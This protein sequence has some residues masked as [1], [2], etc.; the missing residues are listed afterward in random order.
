MENEI[1]HKNIIYVRDISEIGGVETYVYEL[2]KKYK[3]YDI[4]VVFKSCHPNQLARLKRYCYCYQHINQK[5][6]CDVAIINYDSSIIDFITKDIWKENLKEDDPRGIYQG[7]HADYTN[8]VYTVIPQDYRV[9]EYLCITKHVMKTYRELIHQD[10]MRL[11]YN[12]LTIDEEPSPL[13]LVSATRLSIIKGK[14]RMISLAKALDKAKVNYIWYVFTNDTNAINNP[15]IIYMAPRLDVYKW[16]EKADYVVQLSDTEACSYTINEALYRNIP[17]IVTP[18]PYL[19]EIGY[20]DGKTGYTLEFDCSNVNEVAY[21][22]TNKPEFT[23]KHLRDGYKQILSKSKSNYYEENLKE[24]NVRVTYYPGYNDLYLD[25]WVKQDEVLYNLP[26]WRADDLVK[27]N[28][29]EIV[30]E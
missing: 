13:I 27:S 6:I 26:K 14:D 2:V 3:D 25:K 15:N 12:P 5:I 23:F 22:I 24:V 17:I 16:I 21:K 7:V 1:R 29:V 4:A 9:K 20:R 19:N 18:L 10:N 8:A 30:K 28:L 11:C